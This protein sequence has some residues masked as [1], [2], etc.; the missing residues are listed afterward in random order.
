MALTKNLILFSP[1]FTFQ[2]R[3][4]NFSTNRDNKLTTVNETNIVVDGCNLRRFL[5]I[6]EELASSDLKV[7]NAKKLV[8]KYYNPAN[9]KCLEVHM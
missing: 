7:S 4:L 6:F 3:F 8:F 2:T 9:Y 1:L 5:F